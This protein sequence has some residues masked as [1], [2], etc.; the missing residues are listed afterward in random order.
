MLSA[1]AAKQLALE[2]L[3]R[4]LLNTMNVN[5]EFE[6]RGKS[7]S[8]ILKGEGTEEYFLAD[9]NVLPPSSVTGVDWVAVTV[10]SSLAMVKA[11]SRDDLSE[12]VHRLPNGDVAGNRLKGSAENYRDHRILEPGDVVTLGRPGERQIII[13]GRA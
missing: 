6:G 3:P 9:G 2:L 4:L 7:V 5:I 8:S 11:G 10:L 13:F 1:R 12:M